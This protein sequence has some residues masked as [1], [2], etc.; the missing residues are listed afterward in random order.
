MISSPCLSLENM[1][2]KIYHKWLSFF[3]WHMI[4][5][6]MMNLA[7]LTQ[8]Q[9]WSARGTLDIILIPV[10]YSCFKSHIYL[11]YGKWNHTAK[12]SWISKFMAR[13]INRD[14]MRAVVL[15]GRKEETWTAFFSMK[16]GDAFFLL[17]A[18]V[19]PGGCLPCSGRLYFP[20]FHVFLLVFLRNIV[21]DIEL[22]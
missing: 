19:A 14:Y 17:S 1:L 6:K 9:I 10:N 8:S 3:Q 7:G 5:P 20:R 11:N 22:M 15:G 18:W 2:H 4:H 13:N 12:F 16:N 21:Y